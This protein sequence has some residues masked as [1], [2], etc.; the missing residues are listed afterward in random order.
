[1]VEVKTI[2]APDLQERMSN[3]PDL[4]VINVLPK[5]MY[6]DCHIPNSI[7]VPLDQL[8]T[9]VKD[10]D[11]AREIVVY[12]AHYECPKSRQAWEL[13]TKLGFV[14]VFAYEGGMREWHAQGYPTQGACKMDYLE[15]E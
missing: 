9:F 8:A 5:N 7:S 12:C 13:L 2:T 10:F 11:K 4:L 15:E 3:W 1:M 14:R 6:D